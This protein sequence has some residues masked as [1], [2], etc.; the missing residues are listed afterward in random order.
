MRDH[1]LLLEAHVLHQEHLR[2]AAHHRAAVAL[3]RQRRRARHAGVRR[4]A[5]TW[6]ARLRPAPAPC[7]A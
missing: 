6:R 3:R 7:C 5:L 1:Q 4:P 2:Q